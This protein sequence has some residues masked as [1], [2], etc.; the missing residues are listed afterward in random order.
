M[1]V[2]GFTQLYC[3]SRRDAGTTNT[4]SH[5]QHGRVLH[6][7]IMQSDDTAK[8]DQKW[9]ASLGK[10]AGDIDTTL[11]VNLRSTALESVL[12]TGC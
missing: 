7:M 6:L 3:S 9:Q 4:Q 1:L 11:L 12:S 2:L 10:P 5:E 8:Q